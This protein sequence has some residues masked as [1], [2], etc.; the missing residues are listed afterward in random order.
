ALV[1]A[2]LPCCLS[3]YVIAVTFFFYSSG[4]PRDLHSFPTRR[5]SDL[6]RGGSVRWTSRPSAGQRGGHAR[7]V[8]RHAARLAST[9]R[10]GPHREIGRAHVCTPV[11]DQSRMPSS[12]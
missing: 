5:S 12:A 7:R 2:A 8:K 9:R 6:S 1:F 4:A 10:A 3:L 11:T